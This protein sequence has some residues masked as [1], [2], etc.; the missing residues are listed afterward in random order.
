MVNQFEWKTWDKR[1]TLDSIKNHDVVFGLVQQVQE[2]L[3]SSYPLAV[4]ALKRGQVKRIVLTRPA[5]EAGESLG[6]YQ[7]DLR[8]GR[9][10]PSPCL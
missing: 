8:K 7:G 4:T 9:P 6:S 10:L 5:V 1:S 3:S 2:N